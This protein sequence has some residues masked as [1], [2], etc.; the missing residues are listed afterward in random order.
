MSID[1]TGENSDGG[2]GGGVGGHP[3][4]TFKIVPCGVLIVNEN[5]DFTSYL[6]FENLETI[7]TE[8]GGT[9]GNQVNSKTTMVIMGDT[10]RDKEWSTS[11]KVCLP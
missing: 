1:L 4:D 11:Q 10:D 7:I 9:M 3:L 6:S 8:L 2:D 5:V